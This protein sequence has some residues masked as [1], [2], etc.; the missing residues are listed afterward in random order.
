MGGREEL[1]VFR[2]PGSI[3]SLP[4]TV[5]IR[6]LG[7]TRLGRSG[8]IGHPASSIQHLA[9]RIPDP[10]GPGGWISH[11]S[12]MS[13]LR[14]PEIIS[15][16]PSAPIVLQWVVAG[17]I[18]PREP[19]ESVP[20]AVRRAGAHVVE[21]GDSRWEIVVPWRTLVYGVVRRDV[22]ERALLTALCID[23]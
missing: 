2:P 12:S 13:V 18:G 21:G 10:G 22:D 11:T 6:F 15:A 19:A 3:K 4:G 14:L 7:M 5:V 9:S 8:W 23:E 16:R 17:G 1:G 20:R